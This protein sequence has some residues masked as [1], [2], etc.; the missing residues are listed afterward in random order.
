LGQLGLRC[1][2]LA[3]G[4]G[5]RE[6]SGLGRLGLRSVD[7]GAVLRLDD[8][9]AIRSTCAL[10][11]ADKE[12]R[13]G[14]GA[15]IDA[16]VSRRPVLVAELN[17]PAQTAR[18]PVYAAGRWGTIDVGSS[19]GGGPGGED[20]P[21]QPGHRARQRLDLHRLGIK[22]VCEP[23]P[24]ELSAETYAERLEAAADLVVKINET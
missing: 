14:E 17:D 20:G 7:L 18:R 3:L 13:V 6:R 19:P 9:S 8:G 15:C 12:T 21:G 1:D 22:V 4:L 2:H 24:A 5:L 10:T 11:W 23:P 16:A